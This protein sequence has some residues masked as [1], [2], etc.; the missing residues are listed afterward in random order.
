[1]LEDGFVSLGVVSDS[2]PNLF[3][4]E[5]MSIACSSCCCA[6]ESGRM[7]VSDIQGQ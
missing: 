7:C 1:M 6:S 5:L 3:P 2:Y 4:V